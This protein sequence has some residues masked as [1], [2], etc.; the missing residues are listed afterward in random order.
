MAST[1]HEDYRLLIRMLRE[2]REAEDVAQ[3]ELARTLGITQTFIS[4]VERGERRLD[5]VELTELLEALG[6]QP[7]AWFKRFLAN[8]REIHRTQEVKRKISSP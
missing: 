1:H 7:D 8:R 6:V 3:T 5:P 4:K 2:T